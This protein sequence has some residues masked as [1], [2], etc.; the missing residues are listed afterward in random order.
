MKFSMP[1]RLS[2]TI[3]YLPHLL[4]V[5]LIG[6]PAQAEQASAES[7]VLTM[8]GLKRDSVKATTEPMKFYG[9]QRHRPAAPATPSEKN[10][11]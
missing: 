7:K 6:A 11:K 4:L 5:M 1:K 2:R 8:T 3:P 9:L 10:N